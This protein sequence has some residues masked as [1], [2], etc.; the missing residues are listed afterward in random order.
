MDALPRFLFTA[1][2]VF[3]LVFLATYLDFWPHWRCQ[4]IQP[5][6][7]NDRT[8]VFWIGR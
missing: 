4:S 8:C 2:F 5:Y 7:Q 1:L 6:G 3:L